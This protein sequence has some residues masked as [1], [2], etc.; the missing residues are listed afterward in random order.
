MKKYISRT[1]AV[2]MII[3]V[4]TGFV[5]PNVVTN[6][7]VNEAKAADAFGCDFYAAPYA[8]NVASSSIPGGKYSN[9]GSI[10][11]PWDLQT[12]L[13][14][15][16][17]NKTLC[18]RGGVYYGNY[19]VNNGS[20]DGQQ[21]VIKS[22][23]GEWAIL[24]NY[25]SPKL[26]AALP[27]SA[28]D[29]T[30]PCSFTDMD[31]FWLASGNSVFVGKEQLVVTRVSGNGAESV[32]SCKRGMPVDNPATTQYEG[33]PADAHN[34]LEQVHQLGPSF[35][36]NAAN[37]T[38]RDL[39]LRSSIP[40][41][42][43]SFYS[44]SWPNGN[45]AGVT[46]NG[47]NARFI[48]IIANNAA[49]F[50][51]SGAI[52]GELYGNVIYGQGTY[53]ASNRS[54]E[55]AFYTQ[56]RTTRKYISDNIMHNGFGWGVHQY[57]E[58]GYIDN[59]SYENNVFFNA[60]SLGPDGL[61]PD[62]LVGGLRH[63]GFNN[64]VR[65]NYF[66]KSRG[67]QPYGSGFYGAIF[68][69][70]KF[71]API[72]DGNSH[73]AKNEGNIYGN[74][75]PARFKDIGQNTV[76][77]N[78]PTSGQDIYYQSNKYQQGRGF[79]IVYNWSKAA[80][81]GID[82]SKFGIASGP[83]EIRDSQNPKGTPLASG[84]LS[85]TD[86]KIIQVRTDSTAI[87][88]PSGT[89]PK[90]P[91]HTDS[92]FNAFLV[93][94]GNCWQGNTLQTPALAYP[95]SSAPTISITSVSCGANGKPACTKNYVDVSGTAADDK[96]VAL[97]TYQL[98][99]GIAPNPSAPSNREYPAFGTTQW[100]ARVPLRGDGITLNA[101]DDDGNI[102]PVNLPISTTRTSGAGPLIPSLTVN[103]ATYV[104]VQP[105][106]SVTF[107]GSSTYATS[108]YIDNGVG[109][110][111]ATSFTPAS[112][113]AS[114]TTPGMYAIRAIS[115]NASGYNISGYV[116]V[117]VVGTPA[118]DTI[119]PVV[120]I[121]SAFQGPLP[122][123]TTRVTLNA[124]TDETAL[125]KYA[126]VQN[127]TFASATAFSVTSSQ[128][129]ST[130]LTNL[131]SGQSYTY[132]VKCQD[133]AGN[134]SLEKSI[135]FSIQGAESTLHNGIQLPPTWPPNTGAYVNTAAV[136]A[137]VTNPPSAITIDIGRQLFVDD[138]LV[139]NVS[140]LTRTF[141]QPT[142]YA[143]N[144]VIT[145]TNSAENFGT[146][147]AMPYSGAV[148]FDT[149]DSKFKAWYM[150]GYITAI[151]L[152]TSTDGKV[153][154]KPSLTAAG[155]N[156]VFKPVW[157]S[158]P[159]IGSF[160]VWIDE[161]DSAE[162][163]K[164][165]VVDENNRFRYIF[166]TDGI[167]WTDSGIRSPSLTGDRS[168]AYFDPFRNKWVLSL[169][170]AGRTRN[171]FESSVP[172]SA[173]SGVVNGNSIKWLTAD[174]LDTVYPGISPTE[175]FSPQL[176]NFDAAPYESVMLG[177]FVI[178]RAK[179]NTLQ[180]EP[181]RGK[182]K[183][184]YF[185]FSRDSF[186]FYRPSHEQAVK[187]SNISN[188]WNNTNIDSTA[189]GPI[190]VGNQLYFYYSGRTWDNK[191]SMGLSTLRRDGFA[192]FNAG[193][194][195]GSLTTRPVKFTG[196]YLF[197]NVSNIGG[198]L[199]AE[200]LQNGQ[201][202]AGFTK[203][204]CI[205]ITND[206][207]K[208]QLKWNQKADLSQFIGQNVQ[209]KFYL[210]G[211]SLYSF[212]VSPS[213]EGESRGYLAAGGPSYA[214]YVDDGTKPTIIDT[215]PP[216]IA[217]AK[218]CVLTTGQGSC[219]VTV[220]EPTIVLEAQAT[221][222][223]GMYELTY[224]LTNSTNPSG[225]VGD[226][227][228]V[229]ET[230]TLT[231][232]QNTIVITAVDWSNNTS[233]FTAVVTYNQTTT[234]PTTVTCDYYAAPNGSAAGDGSSTSPWDL[235]TALNKT[236]VVTAGKTLCLKGGVYYGTFY[237]YIKGAAGQPITVRSAPGEWAVLDNN[238]TDTLT[239][240]LPAEAGF[241]RCKF[242]SGKTKWT[243]SKYVVVDKE[244]ILISDPNMS[245]YP[246]ALRCQR[247]QLNTVPVAHQV[248]APARPGEV[249]IFNVHSTHT[250]FRDFEIRNTDSNRLKERAV[251]NLD[252][253]YT[254]SYN[255]FRAFG[256][257]VRGSNNKFVNMVVRNTGDAFGVWTDAPDTE[258]YGNLL[259]N[260]GWVSPLRSHGHGLYS[261]NRDG[262]HTMQDNV[263]YNNFFTGLQ[264]FGSVN[265]S[266]NGYR[267]SG[268]LFLNDGTIFNGLGGNSAKNIEFSNNYFYGED[269][270]VSSPPPVEI[271]G[272]PSNP[273]TYVKI[274]DN[275]GFA[276]NA[277]QVT[278]G[279]I[280]KN[281]VGTD[282]FYR[283]NKEETGR[284]LI[285]IYNY[286]KKD[287]IA[288]DL[289]K[290]GASSGKSYEI[291]DVQ[292]LAGGPVR[293]VD[294]TGG[295]IDLDMRLTALEPVES[296]AVNAAIPSTARTGHF[297]PVLR[298][299]PKQFNAFL[300]VPK[301]AFGPGI[302]KPAADTRTDATPPGFEFVKPVTSYPFEFNN[303]NVVPYNSSAA[304]HFRT[305]ATPI[306]VG[307]YASDASG[308]RSL[309]WVN[310]KGG[311]GS[312]PGT[313]A[314]WE[315]SVPLVVGLNTITF[316]ATDK[317]GLTHAKVL[318]IL[319]DP[320]TDVTSPALSLTAP[321][322]TTANTCVHQTTTASITVSGT[323]QDASGIQ[324]VAWTQASGGFTPTT[325]KMVYNTANGTW[326][327]NIPLRNGKNAISV[328][329]IDSS[330]NKNRSAMLLEVTTTATT[331]IDATA[332]SVTLAL[333]CSTSGCSYTSAQ[334]SV[335]VSG[336]A[337]DTSGI[338]NDATWANNKGGS[339]SVSVTGN[340]WTATVG[341]LQPGVNEITITVRDNAATP[342]VAT[343]KVNVTYSA[344]PTPNI[345]PTGAAWYV[346]P[347]GSAAGNGS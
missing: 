100:S 236:T 248:G 38:M 184:L 276:E 128:T 310:D 163:Y 166:S 139:S 194:S 93:C 252:D 205:P 231:P 50:V 54:H 259:Y 262:Y 23:V 346:A 320:T 72:E 274:A 156:V 178:L 324:E 190:I 39:E 11:S 126:T 52:N 115:T 136:P 263:F 151:C 64:V 249:N 135:T 30:T 109:E 62:F 20:P 207:T 57:T 1:L 110:V 340:N 7:I 270:Y 175:A 124:T 288:V 266:L 41:R 334:N 53:D 4:F 104:K 309:T 36:V 210:R 85:V 55:H 291:Y 127:F 160:V 188:A 33:T 168:T 89:F 232:G 68:E 74:G 134:T 94:P 245:T 228:G 208:I 256:V 2:I 323:A 61:K 78:F 131:L 122:S 154:A 214:K 26:A 187:V 129:H 195:E 70:N 86:S 181:N 337:Q 327:G 221:D 329:A 315:T 46:T 308:M 279:S 91:V 29:A 223:Q 275:Y 105:G 328:Q 121:T 102:T 144:P 174:S 321:C 173:V 152:A 47:R 201:P 90:S 191:G 84:T 97:V 80:T 12:A 42:T 299:T 21:T 312:V 141:H 226:I 177:D 48:N 281:P 206:S 273:S 330:L 106:Q 265:A 250:I 51:G 142:P 88:T 83:Y 153:W 111:T 75:A 241:S 238:L 237:S 176:Y 193:T 107:V 292:N 338:K 125:C 81:V 24:E 159:I 19:M 123:T 344:T 43:V 220:T 212:W 196:K 233:T 347:T 302:Y 185:G 311:S 234:P 9:N 251:Y 239:E 96:K 260:N 60:G 171:Y 200:V 147:T 99:D 289:S 268:N 103:G 314:Y 5:I 66:Y 45:G 282:V 148:Y 3:D 209:F 67:V 343:V 326:S 69:N 215:T 254:Y 290:L 227:T 257:A 138:F 82:L 211:G 25:S 244:A 130:E 293:R 18:L 169:R 192:S 294:Y 22:F 218:P 272:S 280:K 6:N 117:S 258:I 119:A 319:L 243:N 44:P 235:A 146:P 198:S 17:G 229:P 306:A 37:I 253:S 65:N 247:G 318:K 335:T 342:N 230:I 40:Q 285:Y 59:V 204:D 183:E 325:G 313:I 31:K 305:N 297:L 32:F 199:C 295:M 307:G 114:F 296:Y 132:Y 155:T 79:A 170:E 331:T 101:W 278:D 8:A 27:A 73:I 242:A 222:N 10:S 322:S 336:T 92:G 287:S 301:G 283:S 180:A 77:S 271:S 339:G 137:Y 316:T 277:T 140:S 286:D 76:L 58:G 317:S 186:N 14:Q 28:N 133:S 261:Q 113:A 179:E 150:C 298:H 35:T 246:D 71:Y 120:N 202:V 161:K 112:K 269:S 118:T 16:L 189:G 162:R 13:N 216:T 158:T 300:I 164:G 284:G 225:K 255:S 341:N 182:I 345:I 49:Y 165:F 149:K 143:G 213:L 264:I 217:I 219:A 203:A 157:S 145:A 56:N 172:R 197:A 63:T 333:P 167:T 116:Y 267:V 224:K 108:L 34:A 87:F 304:V 303:A 15:A 332:P 95:A 98:H 240:A